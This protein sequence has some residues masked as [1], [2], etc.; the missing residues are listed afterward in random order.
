MGKLE[1]ASKNMNI[2]LELCFPIIPCKW[3]L[4]TVSLG[5][6]N[7]TL[8]CNRPISCSHTTHRQNQQESSLSPNSSLAKQ[9]SV[10][11][12]WMSSF[13]T[14]NCSASGPHVLPTLQF[15]C[16]EPAEWLQVCHTPPWSHNFPPASLLLWKQPR[17][18][19]KWKHYSKLTVT[20]IPKHWGQSCSAA[21]QH[22]TTI[23]TLSTETNTGTGNG[24]APR[25]ELLP[26]SLTCSDE[27]HSFTKP[28]NLNTFWVFFTKNTICRY[29]QF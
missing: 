2:P 13:P 24:T 18:D 16:Q 9:R 23:S 19:K 26:H 21:E 1:R 3:D 27:P 22:P 6:S 12:S 4:R 15:P 25:E 17:E 20:T 14:G 7:I 5:A 29:R 11:L 8:A 10:N 28:K